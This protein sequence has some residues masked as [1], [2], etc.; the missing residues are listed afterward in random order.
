MAHPLGLLQSRF[1]GQLI[2]PSDPTFDE[3]RRVHN[4][5]VDRYPA[6]IARCRSAQDVADVVKFAGG[7]GLEIAVRGGGHNVAGRATCDR[8]VVIDLSLMRGVVVDAGSRLARVQ[9]G[10]TWRDFNAATETHHLAAT[11]GVVSS[12]HSRELAPISGVPESPGR[13][14][15]RSGPATRSGRRKADRWDPAAPGP[16]HRTPEDS[17]VGRPRW[18][19]TP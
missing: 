16:S 17:R 19:T 14:R 12:C 9:G 11:G 3:L 7:A 18:R 2:E 13:S 8:G 6:L 15:S 4:G 10:A 5:L 1:S